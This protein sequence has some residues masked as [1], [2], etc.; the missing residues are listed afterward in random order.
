MYKWEFNVC[1]N[2]VVICVRV[3]PLR[4]LEGVLSKILVFVFSV[5]YIWVYQQLFVFYEQP[6]IVYLL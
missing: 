1:A 4:S 5:T 3:V 2:R 6:H